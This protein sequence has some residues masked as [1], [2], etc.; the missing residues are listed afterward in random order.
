MKKVNKSYRVMDYRDPHNPVHS[1]DM[2]KRLAKKLCK[3]IGI[4]SLL[5]VVRKRRED[6]YQDWSRSSC[7]CQPAA[8]MLKNG[9]KMNYQS[10]WYNYI[11]KGQFQI[12]LNKEEIL[13]YSCPEDVA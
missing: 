2:K 12:R 6:N 7:I 11:D 1:K 13:D 3:K 4:G 8:P 5:Q 10:Y 9:K